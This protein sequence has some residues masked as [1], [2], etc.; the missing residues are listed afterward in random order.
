MKN[1]RIGKEQN[2]YLQDGSF[3][4]GDGIANQ[5]MSAALKCMKFMMGVQKLEGNTVLIRNAIHETENAPIT[6]PPRQGEGQ[7]SIEIVLRIQ[8]SYWAQ[9]ANQFAHEALHA[10]LGASLAPKGSITFYM[11]EVLAQLAAL[12]V[13]KNI[14]RFVENEMRIGRRVGY[15][16]TYFHQHVSPEFFSCN[17]SFLEFAHANQ[18]QLVA[19]PNRPEYDEWMRTYISPLSGALYRHLEADPH[20]LRVV[21]PLL[22]GKGEAQYTSTQTIEGFLRVWK[23][24][25]DADGIEASFLNDITREANGLLPNPPI[26]MA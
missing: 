10:L 2:W 11:M 7:R 23:E 8:G 1:T 19:A 16:N 18:P 22:L 26:Q 3:G 5:T 25:L 9:L 24:L 14:G 15:F 12:I 17:Q 13:T 4:V 6:L 20:P 21:R